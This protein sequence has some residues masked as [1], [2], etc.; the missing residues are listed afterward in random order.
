MSFQARQFGESPSSSD[1][2]WAE[3]VANTSNKLYQLLLEIFLDRVEVDQRR[4][5][6]CYSFA[7]PSAVGQS[8]SVAIASEKWVRIPETV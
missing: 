1:Q 6:G 4:G 3:A 2:T 5:E 7:P 8:S